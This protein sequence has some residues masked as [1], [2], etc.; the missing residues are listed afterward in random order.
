VKVVYTRG[1]IKINLK[2]KLKVILLFRFGF[3]YL[4]L[5]YL[6]FSDIDI[7]THTPGL[8]RP[9][10]Q[11]FT[12]LKTCLRDSISNPGILNLFGLSFVSIEKWTYVL[13]VTVLFYDEKANVKIRIKT[14]APKERD[15]Y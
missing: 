5:Y 10:T 14:L 7:Y 12:V 9:N 4:F 2:F 11:S 1:F 13:R 8:S 6:P 15:I 3:T